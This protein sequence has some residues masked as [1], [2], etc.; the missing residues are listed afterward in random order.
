MTNDQPD[1][2]SVVSRPQTQL[3]GS[4][5]VYPI[6]DT[7]K[8]FTLAADTSIVCVLLPDFPNVTDFFIRG[9]TSG[10]TYLHATPFHTSFHPYYVAVINSAVDPQ[11]TV[12]V[13]AGASNT[14]YV[15]SIP[16]PVAQLVLPNQPAPW[17]APTLIPVAIEIT[18]PGA[19]NTSTVIAA[20]SN[21]QSI[22]L[23]SMSW[24]YTGVT[25]GTDGQW[26]DGTP[27]EIMGDSVT[28]NSGPRFMDFKGAKLSAGKALQYKQNGAAAAGTYF[29]HGTVCYSVY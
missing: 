15:S 22:W 10:F 19:G 17:Q 24:V 11:I 9:V 28:L 18:N 13:N 27:T 2:T 25:A 5:W 20:P 14:A 12:E 21:A 26:Q 7:T 23:H 8:T 16:D 29:I 3:T 1:Y 4:P 6:G